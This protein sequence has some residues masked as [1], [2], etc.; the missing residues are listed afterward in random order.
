[1]VLTRRHVAAD[2][3]P[4]VNYRCPLSRIPRWLLHSTPASGIAGERPYHVRGSQQIS[5]ARTP[6][7]TWACRQI[8]IE[9]A[10]ARNTRGQD[11]GFILRKYDVWP[12]WKIAGVQ[13]EPKAHSMKQ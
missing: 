12:T 9:Y 7:A 8:Y 5:S 3:L 11:N 6:Y 2:A 1:M 4:F 13:P 10:D